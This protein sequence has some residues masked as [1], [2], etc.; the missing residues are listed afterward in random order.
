MR[1]F[2][3]V[4]RL[5]LV[6]TVVERIRSV[7]EQGHLKAGDR[8]PTEAELT[9]QLGVSRSVV[10]EAVSHLE[11]VGLLSVQRGRGTFVGNG[12]GVTS[13]VKMLRTALALA[14]RELVQ[15]TEFRKALEGYAARR[16]AERATPEDVAGLETLCD[17]MDR[18][19]RKD[20]EAMQLDFQF[21]R[22]LMAITGNELMCHVLEVVQEFVLAAMVQTTPKPRDRQ[23]SRRRHL[24][25]VR[26]IR[27][28]DPDAAEAAMHQHMEHTVEM[29][30]EME[31]RRRTHA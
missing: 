6:D 5:S 11:S 17:E 19:G 18:A 28:R 30:Q 2:R 31:R 20:L 21:H 4:G 16:A 24:A 1:Q 23:Q 12:S 27:D 22:R 10:R 7:I 3:P 14:P 29:L 8:L 25:I 9:A 15:F 26:A 13:C